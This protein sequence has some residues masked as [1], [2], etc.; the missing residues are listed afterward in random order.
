MGFGET[1]HV[2]RVDGRQWDTVEA[3]LGS[4]QKPLGE[5][6]V[7][8]DTT[9]QL[10][11]TLAPIFNSPAILV[12]KVDSTEDGGI[13][14]AQTLCGVL[15]CFESAYEDLS[16]SAAQVYVILQG[17][18]APK[19]SGLD[20][21][22]WGEPVS[23]SLVHAFPETITQV[24]QGGVSGLLS[25]VQAAIDPEGPEQDVDGV[26]DGG[27]AEHLLPP[28]KELEDIEWEA[29]QEIVNEATLAEETEAEQEHRENKK[30]ADQW[31]K[32]I[33]EW[34]DDNWEKY[35][36]MGGGRKKLINFRRGLFGGN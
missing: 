19:M 30:T 28:E 2:V 22:G 11:A 33:R 6:A 21:W 26:A 15:Q 7:E 4:L 27:V 1:E 23:Y 20:V 35:Y 16:E 31:Q 18:K 25:M 9:I 13:R 5:R 32:E 14:H 12:I 3:A 8:G 34:D 10:I 17:T 36:H 29:G 24:A